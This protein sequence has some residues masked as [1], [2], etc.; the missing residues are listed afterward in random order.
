MPMDLSLLPYELL[1]QISSYLLPRYQC[2]L[3]LT[4]RHCYLYLYNDLLK[5]H[6]KWRQQTPPRYKCSRGKSLVEYNKQLVL[7]RR[8]DSFGLFIYNLTRMRMI[9]ID[10]VLRQGS[11]ISCPAILTIGSIVLTCSCLKNT[12]ILTGCYKYIHKEML[13]MYLNSK[14][15]LSLM[16]INII[17]NII[18]MLSRTD[19]KSFAM[20]NVYLRYKYGWH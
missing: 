16:P 1:Q 18:S 2:R 10:C 14:H 3:A 13:I 11:I 7:H 20:S 12:N 8:V 15:P 4:S 6:A 9:P 19:M 5:W 17:K